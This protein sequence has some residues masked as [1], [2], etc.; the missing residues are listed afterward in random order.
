MS[1]P[2]RATFVSWNVNKLSTLS[3]DTFMMCLSPHFGC[4]RVVAL[5]EVGALSLDKLQQA[6]YPHFVLRSAHSTAALL[7]HSDFARCLT[8]Y[9][10]GSCCAAV[11]CRLDGH[12]HLFA[13]AYLPHSGHGND[14]YEAALDHLRLLLDAA[15]ASS[16]VWLGLD[17]NVSLCPSDHVSMPAAAGPLFWTRRHTDSA[18][19]DQRRQSFLSF[20]SAYGLCAANTFLSADN[21]SPEWTHRPYAHPARKAQIDYILAR[22]SDVDAPAMSCQVVYSV[23]CRSD[24]KPL[25]MTIRIACTSLPN[26]CH[27]HRRRPYT[28]GWQPA[29][30]SA[31]VSFQDQVCLGLGRLPSIADLSKLISQAAVAVPHTTQ[32]H[33]DSRALLRVQLEEDHDLNILRAQ[34]ACPVAK[35]ARHKLA[36]SLF[37]RK[38]CLVAAFRRSKLLE[39][40]K[41]GQRPGKFVQTT[42]STLAVADGCHPSSDQTD[43][44]A[45]ICQHIRNVFAEDVDPAVHDA[46]FDGLEKQARDAAPLQLPLSCLM[47]ARARLKRGKQVGG[48]DGLASE[49][50]MCVPYPVLF[51]LRTLFEKRLN[52]CPEAAAEVQDWTRLVLCFTPKCLHPV[53]CKEFRPLTLSASLQKLYQS[54]LIQL[55]R[56]LARPIVTQQLGFQ[57]HRQPLDIIFVL[58]QLIAWADEWRNPLIIAIADIKAFFDTLQHH[59]LYQALVATGAPLR[60]V[61]ALL[62]ELVHNKVSLASM[63]GHFVEPDVRLLR[64]AKQGGTD[65]PELATRYLDYLL[66][67]AVASWHSDGLGVDLLDGGERYSHS[68]WADDCNF[69]ASDWASMRRMLT[70][71]T[72]AI[73]AGCLRWKP[74]SCVILA[75]TWA[76]QLSD[77]PSTH[78]LIAAPYGQQYSFQLRDSHV[79]LG[80]QLHMSHLHAEIFQHRRS[81][82]DQHFGDRRRQLMCRKC[83]TRIRVVRYYDTV[84]STFSWTSPAWHLR[85]ALLSQLKAWDV[86]H[87]RWILAYFPLPH[88]GP[89]AYLLRANASVRSKLALWGLPSLLVRVLHLH[90]TWAGHVLRMGASSVQHRAALL[91]AHSWRWLQAVAHDTDPA[92]L[93]CWRH[94]RAGR[95][96][97]TWDFW[98]ERF[99]PDL[100]W[101]PR[102][103]DRHGWHSLAPRF[104]AMVLHALRQP[105]PD[106]RPLHGGMHLTQP[107]LSTD[108]LAPAC[109]V[110]ILQRVFALL[111]RPLRP[112]RCQVFVA[113][114]SAVVSKWIAGEA[115]L[116][117]ASPLV[118][119][120]RAAHDMLLSLFQSGAEF[121]DFQASDSLR[122]VSHIPRLHNQAADA[123]ANKGADGCT[124]EQFDWEAASTLLQQ[125]FTVL[126]TF[127]GAARDNP[128]GHAGAGTVL[129]L[130]I[131]DPAL[132]VLS[133]KCVA[134]A[135]AY[136][137]VASNNAAEL[138][139]LL[140]ALLL[141]AKLLTSTVDVR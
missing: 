44:P 39:E 49:M 19:F 78:L 118:P 18:A 89:Q 46:W 72:L 15:P 5:Q 90:W 130:S 68:C 8:W 17:A 36:R 113:G 82:A 9:E 95:R 29:S 38:M 141:L 136:L 51:Y 58:T 119:L 115:Q 50:L 110:A 137:G 31:L 111:R 67:P 12:L 74:E 103:A 86:K 132:G 100:D 52:A 59:V 54:A 121:R 112:C 104:V 37:R 27:V 120:L 125:S 102:A 126:V 71:A 79:L 122:L 134:Q 66:C 85:P 117:A 92:N 105:V 91:G 24:H 56:S 108:L 40:A 21:L 106:L 87:V 124:L 13:S 26:I 11:S 81:K 7:V 3:L 60:L 43:W 57:P 22:R 75:N 109:N 116:D 88:E 70:D 127:D 83:S 98:L 97:L 64:G 41:H 96:C 42:L 48:F 47:H 65:T 94:P 10:A 53:L 1:H 128:V 61:V 114:D 33:R 30:T 84:G 45:M 2:E 16:H 14:A 80:A 32:R 123:L 131:P 138:H 6:V 129:W 4:W 34:L 133:W 35:S 63:A 62:R 73:E 76:R 101:A 99:L 23:D 55:F 25:V 77:A 107:H 139:G 140:L 20:L 28:K 135:S 93:Q 69:A